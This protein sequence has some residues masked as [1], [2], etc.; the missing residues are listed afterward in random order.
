MSRAYKRKVLKIAAVLGLIG[1][2]AVLI[3]LGIQGFLK[4]RKKES[5]RAF[6]CQ[7][8]RSMKRN[9]L[10]TKKD[11]V[12]F[13]YEKGAEENY[14]TR[15]EVEGRRLIRDTAEGSRLME[16]SVYEGEP[17]TDDMRF[18]KYTFINL[19][20]RMKKGDYIDIRISFPNGA[21]FVL[22]SKKQIQDITWP[23]EGAGENA[24][25][26]H[27]SEEE[28]L[29]LSS[30]AVEAF[31]N[32]GCKIYA[33]MYIEKNQK[34]AI[35]NYKVNDVVAQLIED[36]PNIVERAENVL[37]W[38]LWNEWKD[39]GNSLSVNNDVG[40]AEIEEKKGESFEESSKD[41][42]IYFD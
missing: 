15:E 37:E 21:D 30:A 9:E 2:L 7:L 17:I 29:R 32:D 13:E 26:L 4:Y 40:E 27:V 5:G 24:V 18:H 38:Q 34:A 35:M 42:I 16:G 14:L 11:L 10:L 28:I 8:V 39:E 36:D 41:E 1:L 22:L 20:D 19:T 33:V 31:L 12:V 6:G 3:F 23:E 25:W